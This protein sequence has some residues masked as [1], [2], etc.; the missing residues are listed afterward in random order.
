MQPNIF[1]FSSIDMDPQT[2]YLL[3]TKNNLSLLEII[4]FITLNIT[5]ILL[6]NEFEPNSPSLA[7][8]G[9]VIINSFF[10]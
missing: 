1:S 5:D 7:Q 8:I 6:E 9:H 4:Y 10:F 3:E 2:S